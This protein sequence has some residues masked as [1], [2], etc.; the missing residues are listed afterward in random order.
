[1]YRRFFTFI[2]CVLIIV[3]FLYAISLTDAKYGILAFING[4]I[5]SYALFS[6][7]RQPFSVHKMNL[8]FIL[9]FFVLANASQY[10]SNTV[11]S[12]LSVRLTPEHYQ[13][14][15]LLLF[16]VICT[17]LFIYEFFFKRLR[18]L[19]IAGFKERKANTVLLIGISVLAAVL[20]LLHYRH[21][22]TLLLFR[23]VEGVYHST[24]NDV[25][26]AGSLLFSKVLRPIPFACLIWSIVYKCPKKV[27]AVLFVLMLVCLFPTS[28]ARY[29]IVLYW[30]P[31]ALLLFPPLYRRHLFVSLMLVGLLFVF[32]FLGN[33]RYFS[34]DVSF[35]FSFDYLN[36]MNY[37]ASQEFM[38]LMDYHYVTYGKQLLGALLFFV[39][40]A[41]WPG[42]PIG[43]GATLASLQPGA[44]PNISMPFIGEGY[45]NFGF[46]GVFLF[47]IILAMIASLADKTFW[48]A[49]DLNHRKSFGPFYFVLVGGAIFFMRGDL[50]S[51]F[52]FLFAAVVD[53]WLVRYVAFKKKSVAL[54]K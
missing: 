54:V 47:T 30:L 15:Q 34:G 12:S 38:I 50:M 37:D 29:A 11:V 5:C 13:A 41:I 20:V 8:L 4:C 22:L 40:R 2:L 33:F 21:N 35:E 53:L 16:F 45:F 51:S 52:S 18:P 6:H 1:M 7:N 32:P 10:A 31:V 26:V 3:V 14:F 24:D 36:T 28:L 9:F 44:W 19:S 43:S 27:I 46:V 49:P 42:K 23:G 17:Y 48:G 39:P 25:N